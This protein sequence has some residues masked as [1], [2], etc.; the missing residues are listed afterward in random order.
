M[1]ERQYIAYRKIKAA[2]R[3]VAFYLCR[4]FPIDRNLICVCTFEGKGGFGCNPKYIVQELHKERPDLKFVWLVNRVGEHEFP[5]YIRQVPNSFWSS[6]YYLTRSKVWID[7]YRKPLG[8]V[9]RK[10]QYYINT[11]HGCVGFKPI[12]LWRGEKFSRIAYLVSKNDSDMIDRLIVSNDWSAEV[13]VRGMVYDGKILTLGQARED[14]M[15]YDRTAVRVSVR[16]KYKLPVDS[17]IVLYAPTYR[18]SGMK[19]NRQVYS[20]QTSI[21]ISLLKKSLYDKFGGEW[22]VLEKLHPQ[23]AATQKVSDPSVIDV[24]KEDDTNWLIAAS[25]AVVTD[26]SS[27]G[28]EAGAYGIPV[29][30]YMDDIEEYMGDRGGLC[31]EIH[32]D[33]TITN[34]KQMAPDFDVE[35]PFAVIRNNE[36]MTEKIALFDIDSYLEKT[37]KMAE[38]LGW[39]KDGKASNRISKLINEKICI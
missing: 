29:F 8:T 6:A 7:N 22:Y 35:V 28:F 32:D 1:T 25:D 3:S 2:V 15:S 31:F 10:G 16:E 24:S 12:G 23:L 9:K 18:E 17:R 4:I 20:E 38:H 34:N 36:E 26:Y 19:T 30:L 37:K 33:G 11:W 14:V 13:F 39:V 27:V 21:D 5:D